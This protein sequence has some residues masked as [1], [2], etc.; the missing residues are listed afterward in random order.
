MLNWP[1]KYRPDASGRDWRLDFLRGWCLF[2]MVV[3]HAAANH[4]TFL[5]KVTG[6]GGYPM[7]GA[8][9]FVFLSGIV[10]GVVYG[11]MITKEGWSKALPKALRRALLLYVVAVVLGLLDALFGL[12]PWGGGASFVDA[13]SLGSLINTV[14]LHGANDSL[15]TLYLVLV[16][17]APLALFAIQKGRTWLVVAASLSLWIGHLMLPQHFGNP[18]D[19]FVPAAE[20]QVFFASGL[21]IGYHRETLGRWLQGARRH[22]YLTVLFTLFTGLVGLQFA[23]TVGSTFGPIPGT[24]LEWVASQVYTEYEHNPPLHVLAIMVAF[25][26]LY[27]LVDWFWA[28]LRAVLGWFLI[29]IGGAALYVYIVHVAVVY[30]VLL[31][32]P[33]F[34][35]LDG[36]RLGLVLLALMLC[37]WLMVKRR[38]LFQVVPR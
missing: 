33:M 23:V 26:G 19:I 2:S 1:F 17:A 36:V 22:A 3:D 35:E 27:H 37:L 10:F 20:W 32:V 7:T 30:Y 8:H 13:M 21:V 29:P 34:T 15:M 25:L 18:F 16:L 6:N 24:G 38:L 14:T 4:Q 28:P 9:G 11:K 31:H 12:T 5:F